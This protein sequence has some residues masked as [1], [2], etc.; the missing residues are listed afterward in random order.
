VSD[1]LNR[2]ASLAFTVIA[3]AA[4]GHYLV[5]GGEYD[6]GDV[7]QLTSTRT[8]L[9]MRVDSLQAVLD[10]VRVWADSLESDPMVIERVARERHSFIRA[11]ERLFLFV[12]DPSP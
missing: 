6:A 9:T 2:R 10:S 3:I 4:S 11:G 5:W 1:S 12:E 7:K 8:A